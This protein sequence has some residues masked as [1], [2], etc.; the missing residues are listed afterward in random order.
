MWVQER[1]WEDGLMIKVSLRQKS[2]CDGGHFYTH[3]C[4]WADLNLYNGTFKSWYLL[5]WINFLEK[6][7]GLGLTL[8]SK[9]PPILLDLLPY[10]FP[11]LSFSYLSVSLLHTSVLFSICSHGTR[12]I[13]RTR[14]LSMPVLQCSKSLFLLSSFNLFA[15]ISIRYHAW[16]TIS[17]QPRLL[18]HLL[19][20]HSAKNPLWGCP[21]SPCPAW[22]VHS[23]S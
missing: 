23:K 6:L 20:L 22:R 8:R 9:C 17:G 18:R 13:L 4:E 12:S 14:K 19:L 16:S 7:L 15:V 1:W 11:P 10:F 5:D 21:F 2:L 3:E